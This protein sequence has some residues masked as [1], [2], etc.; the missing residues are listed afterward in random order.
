[1]LA[2]VLQKTSL[3]ELLVPSVQ[4][5][6]IKG[7]KT[8]PKCQNLISPSRVRS[9]PHSNQMQLWTGSFSETQPL[10]QQYHGMG[11]LFHKG[12]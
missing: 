4:M 12:L 6:N 7:E 9:L 5:P 3:F 10:L 2:L 1:M 8:K 11:G